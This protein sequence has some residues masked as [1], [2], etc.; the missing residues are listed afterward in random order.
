MSPVAL[1]RPDLPPFADIESCLREVMASGRVT[2]FGQYATLFEEEATKYLGV[3]TVS[4]SS[5][6]VGLI[7]ALQAIGVQPGSKVVIPSFTFVA[8]AQ[9]VLYAG[10]EPIFADVGDDATLSPSDVAFLLEEHEDI[11]AILPVHTYGLACRVDEMRDVVGTASDGKDP[12]ISLVYDAA[13]AFGAR[14]AERPVGTFGDAEVFSLSVTKALV[15]VEG[16]MVASCDESLT[17]SVA[18]MR[19]Y[20]IAE[21]YEASSAGLNGKMSELHAIVGLYNLRR[22]DDILEIRA[23]KAD[24]YVREIE[25]T[26]PFRTIPTPPEIRHTHKDFVVLLPEEYGERRDAVADYLQREG[27]ETRRYFFPPV[28][29]HHFFQRF[30][31]RDLPTTDSLAARVLALPFY[32]GISEDEMDMVV[33]TLERAQKYIL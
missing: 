13:H 23:K 18:K 33:A 31:D 12:R 32:T 8:T 9:A 30:T 21:R 15:S 5:G 7:L 22:L 2:N 14:V 3:G 16:G 6:T 17:A 11:S 26:T 19:N 1:F 20:G 4:V 27:I 25:R 10:A 29:R 24:R 28:H